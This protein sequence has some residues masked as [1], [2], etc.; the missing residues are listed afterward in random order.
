MHKVPA[1]W[2]QSTLQLSISH[3]WFC[4]SLV[5]H[6]G[7]RFTLQNCVSKHLVPSFTPSYSKGFGITASSCLRQNPGPYLERPQRA[8]FILKVALEVLLICHLFTFKQI[9]LSIQHNSAM[10]SRLLDQSERRSKRSR[11]RTETRLKNTLETE[12]G[13]MS[14]QNININDIGSI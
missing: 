11:G 14:W 9:N 10:I 3:S 6:F 4:T 5:A 8:F 13:P 12:T 7:N 2:C 1:A